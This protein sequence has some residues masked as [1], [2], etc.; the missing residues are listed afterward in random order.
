ML[1]QGKETLLEYLSKPIPDGDHEVETYN[2]VVLS[3]EVYN[4]GTQVYNTNPVLGNNTPDTRM[5]VLIYDNLIIESGVILT[6]QVRKR[7]MCIVVK[8]V[9]TNNGTVSMTARGAIAAG[10]NV[11]LHKEDET[12]MF[13]PAAGA[14]GGAS[15]GKNGNS[16]N[17]TGAV[18][19]NGSGRQTGGG[20]SG[21]WYMTSTNSATWSGAGGTGTSYSG[22]S[23]GGAATKEDSA[24]PSYG[25]AGANNGGAGG[26]GTYMTATNASQPAACGGA[27]N[28]GG[29]G[30]NPRG[31]AVTQLNGSVGTGGLLILYIKKLQTL[32]TLRSEGAIGGVSG[33]IQGDGGS[34]G[35]GS[36]NIFYSQSSEEINLSTVFV[37]GGTSR[38]TN[39]GGKGTVSADEIEMDFTL[40]FES[41]NFLDEEGLHFLIETWSEK[42]KDYVGENPGGESFDLLSIYNS[43]VDNGYLGTFEDWLSE[44]LSTKTTIGF[45]AGCTN[46]VIPATTWT[47]LD[48]VPTKGNKYFDN[49]AFVIPTDGYYAVYAQ[50][51]LGASGTA[52]IIYFNCGGVYEGRDHNTT[53]YPVGAVSGVRYYTA[54]T[55]ITSQIFVNNSITLS[56]SSNFVFNVV[57]L[58][59]GKGDPGTDGT[60]GI[61]GASAYDIWLE[62]GNSGTIQDFLDYFKGTDG[63]A[64]ASAYDIWINEGNI[65]TVQDFL[66]SLK[67]IN[68]GDGNSA[69]D[70]W[71]NQGNIGDVEAFLNWLKSTSGGY[72]L[73]DD[74]VLALLEGLDPSDQ[75]PFV[76]ISDLMGILSENS[77]EITD[78]LPNDVVDALLAALGADADN[79]YATQDF[80]FSQTRDLEYWKPNVQYYEGNVVVYNNDIYKAAFNNKGSVFSDYDWIKL[81]GTMNITEILNHMLETIKTGVHGFPVLTPAQAG[82]LLLVDNLGDIITLPPSALG[83][84]EMPGPNK[85]NI[86][87]PANV[88]HV[89]NPVR[90]EFEC[91]S[92]YTPVNSVRASLFYY[93]IDL[94]VQGAIVWTTNWLSLRSSIRIPYGLLTYDTWYQ[95]RMECRDTAGRLSESSYAAFMCINPDSYNLNYWIISMIY[96]TIMDFLNVTRDSSILLFAESISDTMVLR[97]GPN[98]PQVLNFDAVNYYASNEV[99][100]SSITNFIQLNEYS[101]PDGVAM[102]SVITRLKRPD[103]TFCNLQIYYGTNIS[104]FI[105]SWFEFEPSFTYILEVFVT[106][107]N[108]NSIGLQSVILILTLD[109]IMFLKRARI[110]EYNDAIQMSVDDTLNLYKDLTPNM[111]FNND[112]EYKYSTK[113]DKPI[114]TN[115]ASS[116][117]NYIITTSRPYT[118]KIYYEVIFAPYTHLENIAQ[119]MVWMRFKKT[120]ETYTNTEF[121]YGNNI[122]SIIGT[123][124]KL[125]VSSDY[126]LEIYYVDVQY[127]GSE[128]LELLIKTLDPLRFLKPFQIADFNEFAQMS[129]DNLTTLYK[130]I[131][132]NTII[133]IN[134]EYKFL[135]K[136]DKPISTNFSEIYPNYIISVNEPDVFKNRH[137]IKFQPYTHPDGVAQQLVWTRFRRTDESCINTE[138]FYGNNITSI[139]TL[140]NKLEP[141]T[142]YT[143]EIHYVDVNYNGSEKLSLTIKTLDRLVWLEEDRVVC[144]NIEFFESTNFFE[145]SRD[146]QTIISA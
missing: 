102:R 80:V 5:L 63:G 130:D 8:G 142:D 120:D 85:P 71:L 32:G 108:Y 122:S 48:L 20:G 40:E 35:G 1:F 77:L 125:E 129:V 72:M 2:S 127:N 46:Q 88:S 29:V 55:R 38:T 13:V 41:T 22:G 9:F 111:S 10:Q 99:S 84:V 17:G 60:D 33:V 39:S 93:D 45:S 94:Q 64:G 28:P 131:S 26:Y 74:I 95:L 73:T 79:P 27:G 42:I 135:G 36:I 21:S 50:L 52:N 53:L 140:L 118:P 116:G 81:T 89:S 144:D 83:I 113:P 104:S 112:N 87:F 101:H 128:K 133:P 49:N 146:L 61:N 105:V 56:P 109:P 47:E 103:D 96:S 107:A 86:F 132:W 117:P 119:Q 24:N 7:G 23:G 66:D 76:T 54:G 92:T 137:I 18:G 4:L 3:L 16:G 51:S 139:T 14:I 43:A 19:A 69:Y 12:F 97:S 138:F 123:W 68:G 44:I 62:N 70:I 11:Y 65:G 15:H 121:F 90:I 106:D 30:A 134:V 58:S 100:K 31:R 78:L 124:T 141:S 37:N 25:G 110:L 67:G 114:V 126:T 143:L 91:T 136:P 6:P 98:A 145:L 75:N 115:Y 34:S 82:E 57:L 59:G